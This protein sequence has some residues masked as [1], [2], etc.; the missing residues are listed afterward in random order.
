MMPNKTIYVADADLPVFE[1]AQELAGENLSSTIVQALRNF[2][3]AYETRAAGFRDVVVKVGSEIYTRKQ[4]RGRLLAKGYMQTQDDQ[5]EGQ[6][7]QDPSHDLDEDHFGGPWMGREP[8]GKRKN[9]GHRPER[10][11]WGPFGPQGGPGEAHY[12]I[13]EIY[14][15]AKE[16]IALYSREFPNWWPGAQNPRNWERNWWRWERNWDRMMEHTGGNFGRMGN[17]R[18]TYTLEVFDSLDDIKDR[19]SPDLY[20]A[21]KQALTGETVEKLD[22]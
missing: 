11:G 20:H 4:F 21:A 5:P 19:I 12:Y 16:R 3:Q 7:P 15:T 22:I 18:G 2:V 1:R 10:P 8:H 9:R 6:E 13:L 14:Q 17:W